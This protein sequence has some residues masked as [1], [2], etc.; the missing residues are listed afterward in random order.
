MCWSWVRDQ[1]GQSEG[2]EG[3]ILHH[4]VHIQTSGSHESDDDKLDRGQEREASQ[5]EMGETGLWN[6]AVKM[7]WGFMILQFSQVTDP[8]EE[9]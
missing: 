3:T 6:L 4:A 1:L 8:Q 9:T 5:L 2:L 7:G